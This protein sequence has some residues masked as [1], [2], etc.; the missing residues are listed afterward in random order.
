MICYHP[1]FVFNQFGELERCSLR[2]MLSRSSAAH[3]SR[4]RAAAARAAENVIAFYNKRGTCEQWTKEARRSKS[5]DPLSCRCSTCVA[6]RRAISRIRTMLNLKAEI[7][8]IAAWALAREADPRKS[9]QSEGG[10]IPL[11]SP[12]VLAADPMMQA[13][14]PAAAKF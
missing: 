12:P 5:L 11:L 4:S 6:S 10:R 9:P 14:N 13:S 7:A 3:R 2:P 8:V 1:L